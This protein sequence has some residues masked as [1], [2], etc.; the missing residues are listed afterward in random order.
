M[1]VTN[2]RN[3]ETVTTKSLEQMD[4]ETRLPTVKF[5][6]KAV[7]LVTVI[8]NVP[9]VSVIHGKMQLVSVWFLIALSVIKSHVTVAIR[10]KYFRDTTT[11]TVC[12]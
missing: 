1:N 10:I 8:S 4:L 12:V 3:A 11:I 7:R 9:H 5:V 2:P 6:Q